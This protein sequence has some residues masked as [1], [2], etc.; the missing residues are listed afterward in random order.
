VKLSI[1]SRSTPSSFS[2]DHDRRAIADGG[3][4][5]HD[6]YLRRKTLIIAPAEIASVVT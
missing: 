2:A 3:I 5:E 1:F 6:K 4:F